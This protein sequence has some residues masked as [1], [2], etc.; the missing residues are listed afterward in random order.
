MR[1]QQ[2]RNR[3][4]GGRELNREKAEVIINRMLRLIGL[5]PCVNIF[6]GRDRI[7]QFLH[8]N[9]LVND[10]DEILRMALNDVDAD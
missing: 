10:L 1:P 8:E 2:Q 3:R 5:P 9:N 7:Q 4:Q 6:E